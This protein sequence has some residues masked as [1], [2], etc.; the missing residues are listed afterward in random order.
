MSSQSKVTLK[1]GFIDFLALSRLA[2]KKSLES[3]ESETNPGLEC[4]V[5][6]Q[7]KPL[8]DLFAA[9]E[10]GFKKPNFF[11][12]FEKVCLFHGHSWR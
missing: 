7:I 1:M 10:I 5:K 4:T 8:E 3:F 11:T 9:R 6:F 12:I 2:S